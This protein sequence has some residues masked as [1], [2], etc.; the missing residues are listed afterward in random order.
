MKLIYRLLLELY[1]FIVVKH[2]AFV[3]ICPKSTM[4][5]TFTSLP[6]NFYSS[7]SRCGCV[8]GFE[9]KDIGESTDLA[10]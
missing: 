9:K 10:K 7:V 2:V 1:C 4:A 6:L 3:T 8:F 5:F